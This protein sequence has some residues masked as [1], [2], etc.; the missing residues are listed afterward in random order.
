MVPSGLVFSTETI[1]PDSEEHPFTPSSRPLIPA[2]SVDRGLGSP[3]MGAHCGGPDADQGIVDKMDRVLAE[4]YS[5]TEEQ[6]D[7]VINYDLKC[8][9]G[10]DQ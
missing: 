3:F 5:L 2:P 9:K 4:H 7:S 8:R 6:L 10:R 1:I